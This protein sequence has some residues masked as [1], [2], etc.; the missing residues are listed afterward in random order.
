LTP[1]IDGAP[2]QRFGR[3]ST[4]WRWRADRA[5]ARAPASGRVAFAGPLSGWGQVVILDLGPGWRAVVSGLDEAAVE[6]GDRVADGQVLGR[7]GAD[8]EIAFELRRDERPI[9]PAPWLR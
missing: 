8:G 2:S 4:G 6:T 3:G 9:D 5:E 1:P 7:S